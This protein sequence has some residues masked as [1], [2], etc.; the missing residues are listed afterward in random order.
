MVM[1]R[2]LAAELRTLLEGHGAFRTVRTWALDSSGDEPRLSPFRRR[3]GPGPK[4]TMPLEQL[5]D[6][7]GRRVL[8]LLTDGVGPLWHRG[9]IEHGAVP[10]V[11]QATGG[12]SLRRSP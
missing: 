10:M 1:W 6:P 7:T 2:Q 12:R 5:A 9:G 3:Q 8:L 4:R 11:P